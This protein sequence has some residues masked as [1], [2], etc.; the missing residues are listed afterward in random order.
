MNVYIIL[1]HNFCDVGETSSLLFVAKDKQ[2][3]ADKLIAE[4]LL[5]Y[6]EDTD[7]PDEDDEHPV[8]RLISEINAW[9]NNDEQ[10]FSGYLYDEEV[11]WIECEEVA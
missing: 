3:A 6:D 8:L 11:Y 4:L 9:K 2:T 5:S 1:H 7:Q 10:T